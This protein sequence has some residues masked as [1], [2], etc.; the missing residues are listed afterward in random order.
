VLP[1]VSYGSDDGFV[2]AVGLRVDRD[3]GLTEAGHAVHEAEASR[4]QV[5]RTLVI[6]GRLFTVSGEGV[7]VGRLDTLAEQA[8]TAFPPAE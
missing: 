4:G 3:G 1:V 5:E 8:F 6:G 7:E 2:G